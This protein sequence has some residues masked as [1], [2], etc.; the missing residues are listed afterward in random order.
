MEVQ[1]AVCLVIF[2]VVIVFKVGIDLLG[3][4]L[5]SVTFFSKSFY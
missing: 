5:P 3:I 4:D 1:G 2:V